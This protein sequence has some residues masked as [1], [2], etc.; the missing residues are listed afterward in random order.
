[1][2]AAPEPRAP[3]AVRADLLDRYRAAHKTYHELIPHRSTRYRNFDIAVTM[4]FELT[5]EIGRF[6]SENKALRISPA[7]A[8]PN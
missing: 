8:V 1:M 7:E 4:L 3:E 5:A 2:T 6:N